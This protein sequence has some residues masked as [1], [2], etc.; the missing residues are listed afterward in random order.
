MSKKEQATTQEPYIKS[1]IHLETNPNGTI[2]AEVKNIN[3]EKLLR[4]ILPF[5]VNKAKEVLAVASKDK[6]LTQSQFEELKLMMYDSMN[7]AFSNALDMFAPDIEAR[8]NLTAEAII[9]A[10]DEL[11]EEEMK[12]RGFLTQEGKINPDYKSEVPPAYKNQLP[13]Q[14]SVDEILKANGKNTRKGGSNV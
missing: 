7:I 14:M 10:Q 1:V 2:T 3:F 4:M 8:P 6:K 13:G 11:L 5:I 12:K 9:K